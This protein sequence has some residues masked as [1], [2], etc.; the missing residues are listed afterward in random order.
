MKIYTRTGD[1][2]ETSLFAGGRISKDDV[3]LH[4]YG[5]IDEL[6]SVIGLASA[7]GLAKQLVE[8]VGVIQNELFIVG[9]DLATPLDAK[10]DWILRLTEDPVIRLEREIDKM[11]EKLPPLKNFILPGGTQ[12]A[13]TL[14]VARTICR[15][16]ERWIVTLSQQ[17][18]MNASVIHYINRLSDWLFTAA[19]YENLVASHDDTIWTKP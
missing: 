1:Q 11:D 8:W 16:A 9:S 18:E 7:Q 3:R 10:S 13:A 17:T 2:G 4:A 19:R 6:N 15:R 12:G 14:H 5:T